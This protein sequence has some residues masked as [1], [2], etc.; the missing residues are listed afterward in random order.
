M[1]TAQMLHELGVSGEKIAFIFNRTSDVEQDF[2]DVLRFAEKTSVARADAEAFVPESEL[3]TLLAD[4][5][6]NIA[7]ALADETDWK[8]QLKTASKS[9]DKK[10]FD[11]AADMI[12]I[13]KMARSWIASCSMSL[14]R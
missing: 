3:F 14:N 6:L 1:K 5:K 12:A 4:K 13:K 11:K 10:G 7:Q 2:S 8:A 9:G